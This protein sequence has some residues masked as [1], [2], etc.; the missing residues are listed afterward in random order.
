MVRPPSRYNVI[1][2][3]PFSLGNILAA[4]LESEFTPPHDPPLGIA[5]QRT[6]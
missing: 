2:W 1:L 6:G 5:P 3:L 4:P